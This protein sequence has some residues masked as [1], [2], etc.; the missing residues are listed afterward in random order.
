MSNCCEVDGKPCIFPSS[1]NRQLKS[2]D[3]CVNGQPHVYSYDEMKPNNIKQQSHICSADGGK[4]VYHEDLKPFPTS[5]P[6]SKSMAELSI[7]QTST[8]LPSRQSTRTQTR[9]TREATNF[10]E[11]CNEPLHVPSKLNFITPSSKQPSTMS[12]LKPQ[13]VQKTLTEKYNRTPTSKQ[14]IAPSNVPTSV[15]KPLSKPL[16][17]L[18]E[19]DSVLVDL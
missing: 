4:H 18:K 11:F 14:S 8:G 19:L 15:V 3:T 5:Q 12:I 1:F 10:N 13:H 6:L 16:Q 7:S 17:K 2:Q 9:P